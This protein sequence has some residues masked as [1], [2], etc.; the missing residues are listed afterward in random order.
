MQLSEVDGLQDGFLIVD[1]TEDTADDIVDVG[2]VSKGRPV[3]EERNG[4]ALADEPCE[5]VDSE[6]WAL[7]GSVDGV[8]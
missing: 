2:V 4:L 1:S 8:R 5:P 7:T 3:S 6:I